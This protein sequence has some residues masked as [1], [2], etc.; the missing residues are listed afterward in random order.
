MKYGVGQDS[1][2][3][4]HLLRSHSIELSTK[5]RWN[6]HLRIIFCGKD[7]GVPSL[8]DGYCKVKRNNSM[9]WPHLWSS[10]FILLFLLTLQYPSF[11]DGTPPS[12]P[13]ISLPVL[14]FLD[15]QWCLPS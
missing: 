8:N 3:I 15:L 14:S 12:F 6:W 5:E 1:R 7:G 2:K 10:P 13:P 9:D 11:Q 4:Y